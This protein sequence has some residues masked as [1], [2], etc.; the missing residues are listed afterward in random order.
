MNVLA[1]LGVQ[2]KEDPNTNLLAYCFNESA[3]F[4]EIFLGT[5]CGVSSSWQAASA[6]TRVGTGESGIPDLVIVC[7]ATDRDCLIVIENKLSADEGKDQT[8]R[9]SSSAC[10]SSLFA[11]FELDSGRTD[12]HYIFFTR[13]PDQEPTEGTLFRTVRH[14]E[15]ADALD[16]FREPDS[17][18]VD[19]LARSWADLVQQMYR[20]GQ[21]N[22]EDEVLARLRSS[23]TTDGSYLYFRSLFRQSSLPPDLTILKF[24]KTSQQGRRYFLAVISKPHWHPSVMYPQDEQYRLDPDTSFHIHFEPQFNVLNGSLNLY[25]HYEVNP[26][27]TKPW[28]LKN[29]HKADYA[30]YANRR[31]RFVDALE[32]LAPKSL[33]L[34]GGS[35]QIAKVPLS[36]DSVR[37]PAFKKQIEDTLAETSDTIDHILACLD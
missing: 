5:V 27:Q 20:A 23:G 25:I 4:R 12:V 1:A 33:I 22:E 18:L 30:G 15:L 13:F 31:D 11:R 2:N 16:G 17:V 37:Y 29:V 6:T 8:S 7:R 10:Q 19:I 36:L 28:A 24:D 14:R 21:L 34:G 26:Y 9:Y 35:N 32:S 3:R